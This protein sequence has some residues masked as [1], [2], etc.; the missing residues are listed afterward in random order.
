LFQPAGI[1]KYVEDLKQEANK[2]M[3]LKI[4]LRWLV[5]TDMMMNQKEGRKMHEIAWRVIIHRKPKRGYTYNYYQFA[6]PIILHLVLIYFIN[7]L[8]IN[9]VSAD[10]YSWIDEKGVRHYSNV[11][12][13]GTEDNSKK[14]VEYKDETAT[15]TLEEKGRDRFE[16]LRRYKEDELKLQEQLEREENDK[17]ERRKRAL[18]EKRSKQC[19]EAQEKLEKL[20]HIKWERYDG[21]EEPG[22]RSRERGV[23]KHPPKEFEERNA[24]KKR[25]YER[26]ISELKNEIRENCD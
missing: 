11:D 16:V 20:K 7:F 9:L 15:N 4:L 5:K 1:L 23:R 10:M 17:L 12:N 24:C 6:C 8:C 3:G 19:E 21:P 25:A 13:S 22:C 2:D 18:L 26:R 14:M